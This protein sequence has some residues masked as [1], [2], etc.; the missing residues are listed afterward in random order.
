MQ[1]S[2]PGNLPGLHARFGWGGMKVGTPPTDCFFL[3]PRFF[4]SP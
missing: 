4:S 3:L 1:Q 2:W